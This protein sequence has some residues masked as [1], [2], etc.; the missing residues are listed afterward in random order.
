MAIAAFVPIIWGL[1]TGRLEDA[2]WVTLTAECICWVEL[3][4]AFS[5]RLRVLMGG[6]VLALVFTA[7]GTLTANSLWLSV[8]CMLVVGFLSGLFKNL[9][10]RGSGLAICVYVIF[11]IANAYP[12][13]TL[14]E[15][16]KRLLLVLAGG[17][18]NALAGMLASAFMTEQQPYRRTIGVIWKAISELL[19]TVGKGWDG[20]SKRSSIRDIYLKEKDV[21][22]A[23]DKS[24]HFY[25]ILAHQASKENIHEYQLAQVRKAA[26]IVAVNVL[27][28]SDELE[29]VKIN[30]IDKAVRIKLQSIL[31]AM[32]Q[33][34]ERMS[35]YVITLKE[36]EEILLQSRITRLKKLLKILREYQPDEKTKQLLD[37][38]RIAQLAERTTKILESS[39]NSLQDTKTDR[40]VYRSYSF[41]KTLFILHP[42]YWWYNVKLLFNFNTLT[43][44]YAI[45]TAA[46]SAVA[47]FISKYFD[48]DRGYWLA[49]TVILV[50]QPYIGDTIKKAMDRVIGTVA[51]SIAGGLLLRLPTGL[52]FKEAVLF[53]CFVF[54]VYFIRKNYPIA[55]FFITLSLV[56]LFDVEHSFNPMLIY[57]R[58][59]STILG[60][61]LGIV[62]GFALLPHR[63]KRQ[64]PAHIACSIYQNYKYFI[65]TFFQSSNTA[66]WT[67]MKKNAESENSNAFD[68]YNRYINEP[69]FKKKS[70]PVY[71]Q[72]ITHNVRVTRELNNIH[73][74]RE[75]IKEE[76]TT[77]SEDYIQKIYNCLEWF[78]KNIHIARKLNPDLEATIYT[79]D[80]LQLHKFKLTSQQI[81][82][83][84]KMRLEL[85]AMHE[86]LEQITANY[87]LA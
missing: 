28:I 36:E 9:G 69:R 71:F 15:L 41:I 25:S 57:I 7:V 47:I 19:A 83:L 10:D 35:I 65:A 67:R 4:G 81:F 43:T 14:E 20:V 78:N 58:T 63:D 82:W 80:Q 51:G 39:I 85:E 34:V 16:E 11:I 54:M 48:I 13:H 87:S 2:S 55:V 31:R 46:A 53:M 29:Q 68:S 18:W 8:I 17:F 64:L 22:T 66:V 50:I 32:Q 72:M 30:E 1:S 38:P 76:V 70:M 49:F 52:Y 79:Q 27:A 5:Q 56:L 33:C 61:A 86:D 26:A 59:G 73:S 24:L 40:P 62:A 44:K 21:R 77:H 6:I 75:I 23:I 37:I 42:R 3:K 45:R 84:E 74:E 12:V 60:A